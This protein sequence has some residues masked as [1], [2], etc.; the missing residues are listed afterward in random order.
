MKKISLL[1]ANYNN[2]RYFTD[3]YHSIIGQTYDNWEVIIVDDGSTDNSVEIIEMLIEG[4]ARFLLFRNPE[5]RGCGYTK[6]KC[7]E[8]ATGDICAYIDPDDA[9]YP[10]AVEK[11]I[12]GYTNNN[13]VGTYSKM[14]MCDENL[15]P[16]KIFTKTKKIYNNKYFFNCPIQFS[17]FFTFRKHTYH[18]TAGIN[19][20]LKT[21][22]DQDLYLKILEL[23]R[24]KFVQEVLYKYRLHS[25]GI[26]QHDTQKASKESFAFVI[27]NTMKRRDINRVNGRKIPDAYNTPEEI[28][29][30]LNYQNSIQ[31]R[32]LN[33]VK[34]LLK[35]DLYNYKERGY[36]D[37]LF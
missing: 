24:V 9:L 25:G 12:Q 37:I 23:G 13:I 14:M 29:S 20:E 6:K 36:Q 3:C 18:K 32:L 28:F 33:K 7:M 16:Q 31:Y 21:A 26:S 22:V 15:M 27:H 35:C 10:T 34:M 19:P 5:N 1:I 30:L 2:G 4:D 11:S 8:Y 17:H